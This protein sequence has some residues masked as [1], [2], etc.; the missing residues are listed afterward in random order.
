[1]GLWSLGPKTHSASIAVVQKAQRT[2]R[3]RPM[4]QLQSLGVDRYSGLVHTKR[5]A[6]T[7]THSP[8]LQPTC[9]EAREINPNPKEIAKAKKEA[10][11]NPW[12]HLHAH[13]HPNMPNANPGNKLEL[14]GD[15][16]SVHTAVVQH[17]L[18]EHFSTIAQL[19]PAEPLDS[20]QGWTKSWVCSV[21]V[22]NWLL[23]PRAY[24]KSTS[25]TNWTIRFQWIGQPA[26]PDPKLCA[27]HQGTI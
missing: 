11:S 7:R 8:A 23:G 19:G 6:E 9:P 21:L 13:F 10:T 20:R 27:G 26:V 14:A 2:D 17:P 24:S 18:R 4:T 5:W 25:V 15:L 1:M 16:T 22:S 12:A 3:G